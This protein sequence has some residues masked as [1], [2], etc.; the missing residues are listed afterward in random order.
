MLSACRY[1]D[2]WKLSERRVNL[3]TYVEPLSKKQRIAKFVRGTACGNVHA[4][5]AQAG[6]APELV[7]Q[8]QQ[9]AGQ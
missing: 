1:T 6:L 8:P 2:V 3:F 5:W 9:V 4:A 7:Q